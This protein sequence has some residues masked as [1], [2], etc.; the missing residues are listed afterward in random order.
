MISGTPK[1]ACFESAAQT[2][3]RDN[4]KIDEGKTLCVY[5][6]GISLAASASN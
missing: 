5:L 3:K 4:K 1:K 6:D 2:D